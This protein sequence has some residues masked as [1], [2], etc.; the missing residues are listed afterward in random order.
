MEKVEALLAEAWLRK[1]LA[2]LLS[3]ETTQ[4]SANWHPKTED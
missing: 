2:S 4:A 3:D 1:I